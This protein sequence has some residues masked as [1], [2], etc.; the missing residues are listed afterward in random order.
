MIKVPLGWTAPNI[1]NNDGVDSPGE[2]S[3]VGSGSLSVTGGGGQPWQ[4]VTT[5]STVVESGNT[6]VFIL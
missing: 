5:T 1:D 3:L 6:L 2:V 4:L